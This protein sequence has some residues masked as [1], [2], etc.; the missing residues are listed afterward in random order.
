MIEKAWA[1]AS[2][3]MNRPGAAYMNIRNAG[4]VAVQLTGLKTALA[5]MPELHLTTTRADG[6]STMEPAGD[7]SIPPGETVALAPGGLHIMLIKLQ[8][9]MV[10]GET[11]G[12]TLSFSDRGEHTVEVPIYGLAA[13]GP[14]GE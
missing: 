10:K 8:E 9:P 13:T 5:M 1:R 7:I 11:F 4:D 6:V 14:E 2:I 12:L 3:G